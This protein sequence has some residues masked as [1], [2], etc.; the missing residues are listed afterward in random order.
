MSTKHS[1]GPW[2]RRR[3]PYGTI[4]AGPAIL[5]HPGRD[6]MRLDEKLARREADADLI[7]AAPDMLAALKGILANFHESVITAEGLDEFPA[8]KAVSDAIAKAEGR[9]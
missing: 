3:G 1:P 6:A 7:L 8:L 9:S 5:E 4:V 2:K